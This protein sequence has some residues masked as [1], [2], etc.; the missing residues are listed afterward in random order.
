MLHG[1]TPCKVVG[2]DQLRS[3]N[4]LIRSFTRMNVESRV[5]STGAITGATRGGIVKQRLIKNSDESKEIQ[6]IKW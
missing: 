2:A 5:N 4:H 1:T 6:L 3:N